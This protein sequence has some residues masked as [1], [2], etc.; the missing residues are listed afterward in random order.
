MDYV[1]VFNFSPPGLSWDAILIMTK[2]ALEL[3]T[4]PDK[5]IFFGKGTRD[6]ISYISNKFSKANNKYLKSHDPK[7]ELK[8]LMYLEQIIYKVSSSKWIKMDRPTRV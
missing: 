2:V 3:I 1:Q 4:D 8:H 5:F 6:R 7:Q